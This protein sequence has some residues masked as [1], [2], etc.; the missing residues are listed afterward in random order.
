MDPDYTTASEWGSN[1]IDVVVNPSSTKRATGY[2]AL[3]YSGATRLSSPVLVV[4]LS[5]ELWPSGTNEAYSYCIES[6]CNRW[7]DS[8]LGLGNW[9]DYKALRST[10]M[11]R[12]IKASSPPNAS[13]IKY[14]LGM[15]G[16]RRLRVWRFR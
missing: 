12:D 1:A 10:C 9:Q 13:Q 2:H 11:V 15:C 3:G 14:V 16:L 4:E 6:G 8:I 7:G 5:N